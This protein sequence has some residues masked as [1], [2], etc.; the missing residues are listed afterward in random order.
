MST[1]K[2]SCWTILKTKLLTM[3]K[4]PH[5]HKPKSLEGVFD[6][7]FFIKKKKEIS[8][9]V[10]QETRTTLPFNDLFAG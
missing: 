7:L 8:A 10:S 5:R 3:M 2:P 9:C 4:H 6:T 1:S